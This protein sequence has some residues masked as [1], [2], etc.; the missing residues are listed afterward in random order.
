MERKSCVKYIIFIFV[1]CSD[2]DIMNYDL[3][4]SAALNLISRKTNKS[5]KSVFPGDMVSVIVSRS[6]NLYHGESNRTVGQSFIL[7]CAE[8]SALEMMISNNESEIEAMV[9]VDVMTKRPVYPCE[10]CRNRI[11]ALSTA[12]AAAFVI[13]PDKSLIKLCE[14]DDSSLGCSNSETCF[15]VEDQ[16]KIIEDDIIAAV[17]ENNNTSFISTSFVQCSQFGNIGCITTSEHQRIDTKQVPTGDVYANVS[18][19]Q[20]AD[21]NQTLGPNE[22]YRPYNENSRQIYFNNSFENNDNLN[23]RQYYSDGIAMI[24]REYSSSL[25]D[26]SK[27]VIVSENDMHEKNAASDIYKNN[28]KKFFTGETPAIIKNDKP[29]M[30]NFYKKKFD[31]ILKKSHDTKY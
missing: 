20:Y 23:R 31:T 27:K 8:S 25:N 3:I 5:S 15:F 1:F 17:C 7:T 13:K 26:V 18:Y 16:E 24:K 14:I 6:G 30:E 9:V 29:E 28:V 22:E 10:K 19:E 21:P 11:I 12:N 4:Y 2:D